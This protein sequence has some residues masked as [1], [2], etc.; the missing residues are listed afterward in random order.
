MT[1]QILSSVEN[2]FTKG[3][4]T[5]AT[6]LNFPENACTSADN[7]VFTLIG[8]VTRRGGFNF[9]EN[10]TLNQFNSTN[11]AINTYK[12]NNAGGDGNTQLLVSQIGFTLNFYL[13][14]NATLNAP[15]SNQLIP[16]NVTVS[17]F[18]AQGNTF[19]P[20]IECQFSDGNGYLFV[21]HP[22][23]D[24]FYVIYKNGIISSNVINV[25]IRDFVGVNEFGLGVTTRPA[26]L[27][28]EHLY[29]LTNQGWTQGNSWIASTLSSGY[30]AF[31]ANVGTTV[32]FTVSAGISG[33]VSGTDVAISNNQAFNPGGFPVIP[34]GTTIFSGNV[35]S[36]SGTTL[37][38]T[39]NFVYYSLVGNSFG[40]Q[41]LTFVPT[42]VG[43]INTWFTALQN[44]PS[45]ADVWW[46]FKNNSDVYSPGTTVANVNLNTGQAPQGH[47]IFSAFNQ[48][49][50]ALSGVSGITNVIT[51]VRPS[52]G[53]WFQGRVWFTGVN[54]QQFATG[55]ALQY[56]WTENIYFSQVVTDTSNFGACYQT[57]DPTSQTLFDL[58]PT[59]GGVISIQGC[60]SIYKLFP[61]QNGMLVFAANGVWFITGSTGIGFSANDYT[62]TKISSVESISSTSYVDV[63]GLPYFWNEEGIYA[64]EPQQ[65]GA[66]AVNPIT[67][68]TILS[69]YNNIPK[70]SKKYVRGAYH[71]INYVIQWLYKSTNEISITD[72]YSFD[73]ILNYNTFN[74]AFYPYS[75]DISVGPVINGINYVVGPGG[76][77]SPDPTFKY[78]TSYTNVFTSFTFS[79]ENDTTTFTDFFLYNNIGINFVS[80]FTTGFKLHGQAQR[81]FQLKYLYTYH[82]NDVPTSVYLQGVW[83]YAINGNSGRWSQIQQ[84][85]NF[86]PNFGMI[87]RRHTIRGR[88]LVLQLQFTS[89]DG[90]PFDIMGW[91]AYE[92]VNTGV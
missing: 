84:I 17:S 42:N 72:R 60:G 69:F 90:Q 41:P 51:S 48:T 85:N 71:P 89:V 50:S 73:S 29:N 40:G 5:E 8:D 55:D 31:N 33:I 7:C 64:V 63:Q 13:I 24:P 25:Q 79:E 66:L 47:I 86:N 22:N 1:S 14:T 26:T 59:D 74:K 35:V 43:F 80:T 49:R 11:L 83:D 12:W 67:V 20:T 81:R 75:F 88:G 87:A 6:G 91:S 62:I 34:V 65:G 9:E 36:Y 46:Y 18:L 78:L 70:Q 19:D 4:I 68:G 58:L 3:L 56:S 61:I 37:T 27:T 21:Y 54:A 23:C 77:S 82:R 32:S 39:L 38:L 10:Y 44:Y 57:N 45:N 2:N 92:T 28:Q 30:S 53:A 15:L 52:T 76:S 16:S